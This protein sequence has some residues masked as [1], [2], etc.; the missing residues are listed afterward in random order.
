MHECGDNLVLNFKNM[1]FE[2]LKINSKYFKILK[3]VT[4]HLSHANGA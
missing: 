2:I 4:N 3:I 1:E